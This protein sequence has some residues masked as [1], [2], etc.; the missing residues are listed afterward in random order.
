MT[1]RGILRNLLLSLF[2]LAIALLLA[3]WVL[4]I[5]LFNGWGIAKNVR[6]ATI[7]SE[8]H[9]DASS[10]MY[11]ANYWKLY[12]LFGGEERPPKQPHPLLGWV[13]NFDRTSLLHHEHVH[14]GRRRPVL[15]YGDS[16]AQCV[17][18]TCFQDILKNDSAFSTGHYLLN[19]GVGGFGLDQIGLLCTRS[20]DLYEKPFVVLSFMTRDLERACLDWRNGEKPYYT[21]ENDGLELRNSPID[22]DPLRYLDEHPPEVGSYLWRLFS[23][24]AR[25]DTVP[26]PEETEAFITRAKELNRRILHQA[27]ADLRSRGLEFM[28]VVF[29][30]LYRYEGDWRR[31]FIRD[32]LR[33]EQV[34]YFFTL[35]LLR[36]NGYFGG[37]YQRFETPRHGH[38]TTYQNEQVAAMIAQCAMDPRRNERLAAFNREAIRLE[39]ALRDTSS[40]EYQISR[41]SMDSAWTAAVATKAH[42]KGITLDSMLVLDALWTMHERGIQ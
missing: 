24:V 15:L 7:Y 35:D 37:D 41:I 22:P 10:P 18:S 33:E 3:E 20:V 38:P 11:A 40:L 9:P 31:D 12:T 6:N 8:V 27:I 4:R 14:V 23:H 42:E 34:P 2:S 13:G 19:Y 28:V 5:A 17:E 30:P 32:L 26:G 29:D 16:F 21:L 39:V 25:K 1:L 36:R